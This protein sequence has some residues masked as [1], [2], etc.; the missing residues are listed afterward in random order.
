[1]QVPS[2]GLAGACWREKGVNGALAPRVVFGCLLRGCE[3]LD[4][5]ISRKNGI[6]AHLRLR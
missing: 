4:T 6:L 2:E 5:V 1:M 3:T